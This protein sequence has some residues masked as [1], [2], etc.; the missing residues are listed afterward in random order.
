MWL[1]KRSADVMGALLVGNLVSRRGG[2][3]VVCLDG[4]LDI[5]KA[6]SSVYYLA[7]QWGVW[8]VEW[9]VVNLEKYLAGMTVLLMAAQWVVSMVE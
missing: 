7:V 6:V 9:L 2:R 1:E 5:K 8:T 4:C 3:S